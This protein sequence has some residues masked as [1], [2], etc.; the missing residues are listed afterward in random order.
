MSWSSTILISNTNIS[1]QQISLQSQ[2]KIYIYN[3]N[4]KIL[5]HVLTTQ[6]FILGHIS[7]QN[8]SEIMDSVLTPF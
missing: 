3:G 4:I 6:N 8:M 2:S 1:T 7:V 5:T